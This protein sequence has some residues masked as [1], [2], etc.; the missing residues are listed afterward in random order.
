MNRSI[1]KLPLCNSW[2][3][4]GKDFPGALQ[5]TGTKIPGMF[6][7]FVKRNTKK[8]WNLDHFRSKKDHSD[9]LFV[10]FLRWNADKPGL[11]SQFPEDGTM[12]PLQSIH[13][14]IALR[15]PNYLLISCYIPNICPWSHEKSIKILITHNIHMFLSSFTVISFN[16]HQAWLWGFMDDSINMD[17]LGVPPCF[18]T[19]HLWLIP[20]YL[21]YCK[22]SWI[23]MQSS[24]H[25][26][27]EA[28]F[29]YLLLDWPEACG[30]CKVHFDK[31]RDAAEIGDP[32]N[33]MAFSLLVF[34]HFLQNLPWNLGFG[35]IRVYDWAYHKKQLSFAQIS[36]IQSIGFHLPVFQMPMLG[37]SLGKPWKALSRGLDF[38]EMTKG[39][40]GEISNKHKLINK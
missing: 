12:E 34:H 6:E 7:I 23:P 22:S 1:S 27:C 32:K 31:A 8:L 39:I 25:A 5:V 35:F 9:H 38:Q 14:T 20:S 16:H 37:V 36:W 13:W 2:G 21:T 15:I 28:E 11:F 33:T 40:S 17:D 19:P 24:C 10:D 29:D 3:E 30:R 18:A 26:A 4:I